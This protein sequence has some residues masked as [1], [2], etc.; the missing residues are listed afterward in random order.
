MVL[1]FQEEGIRLLIQMGF[2]E[3][4]AKL[5]LGTFNHR[6]NRRENPI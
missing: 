5:Y 6:K 2:T 3:T 1:A 4:Q